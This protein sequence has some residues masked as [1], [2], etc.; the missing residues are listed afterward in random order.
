MLKHLFGNQTVEKIQFFLL[1]NKTC[2]A[3][4]LKREVGGA[5]APIQNALDRLE[6]GNVIVSQLVGRTRLYQ[7]NPRYPFLKELE[8][9]LE[10][11]YAFLPDEIK[12]QYY[13]AP[14]RKRPRKRGKAL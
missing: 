9:L 7:F 12:R 10:R 6:E 4:Q 3:S 8:A 14:V 11:A 1:K 5:L 13:E 2:Y